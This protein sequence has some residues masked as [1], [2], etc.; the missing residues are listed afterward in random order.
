M[1]FLDEAFIL[2]KKTYKLHF[3]KPKSFEI[4][5]RNVLRSA[6]DHQNL[7]VRTCRILWLVVTFLYQNR[8][9]L[10]IQEQFLILPSMKSCSISQSKI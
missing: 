2:L 6:N 8:Y 7:S 3:V 9:I 4:S 1:S 10:T 5:L